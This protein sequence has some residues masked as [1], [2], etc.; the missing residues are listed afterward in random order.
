M[1]TK[2]F[3]RA[4]IIR[5]LIP[6]WNKFK[7]YPSKEFPSCRISAPT[8]N[9]NKQIKNNNDTRNGKSIVIKTLS[10]PFC[11]PSVLF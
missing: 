8:H 9:S 3:I 6:S 7:M 11:T 4:Y 10:K 1:I 2:T 5:Q